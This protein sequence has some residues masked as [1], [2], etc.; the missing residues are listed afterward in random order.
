MNTD[1]HRFVLLHAGAQ[2][3]QRVQTVGSRL[4]L[5]RRR[6]ERKGESAEEAPRCGGTDGLHR[7]HGDP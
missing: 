4:F 5:T 7:Y 3:A 6:K 1:A 2:G